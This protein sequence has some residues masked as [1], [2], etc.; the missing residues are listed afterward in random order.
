VALFNDL[1]LVWCLAPTSAAKEGDAA[2]AAAQDP[3]QMAHCFQ[4]G[5]FT[6]AQRALCWV[7]KW[8]LYSV[9]GC[10]A[11]VL[12]MALTGVVSRDASLLA[13]PRLAR[14]AL[15]GCLHLGISANSRYQLVNG[16]EVLMYRSLPT[17]VARVGSVALRFANNCL[18]A[19]L[20]IA[21]SAAL[22]AVWPA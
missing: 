19:R 18:G 11:A 13:A 7:R 12:S 9:I 6:V 15:T 21:L 8:R 14:A 3:A 17:G 20:W 1:A 2:A 4:P 10:A 22:A 16:A 5:D